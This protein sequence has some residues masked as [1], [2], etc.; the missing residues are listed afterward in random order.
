MFY[1]A[2]I[3]EMFLG[4]YSHLVSKLIP[5]LRVGDVV[6]GLRGSVHSISEP[7]EASRRFVPA[8]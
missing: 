2:I 3:W 6:R 4:A 1:G 8:A 7:M 5:G